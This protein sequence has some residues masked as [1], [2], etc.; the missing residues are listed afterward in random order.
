MGD[1]R[2]KS[3]TF[4]FSFHQKDVSVWETMSEWNRLGKVQETT[5]VEETCSPQ[6]FP[7]FGEISFQN[8]KIS[9]NDPSPYYSSTCTFPAVSPAMNLLKCLLGCFP[10][11]PG[12]WFPLWPL[13]S[14]GSECSSGRQRLWH[15]LTPLSELCW[16]SLCLVYGDW[17]CPWTHEALR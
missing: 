17:W 6:L 15:G 4:I 3:E 14:Q 12:W 16:H 13:L 7:A 2:S 9:A 5:R 1:S 11:F 10:S 8:L